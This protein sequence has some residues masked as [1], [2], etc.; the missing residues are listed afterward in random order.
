MK[1]TI[2]RYWE[3][4]GTARI[5]KSKHPIWEFCCKDADTNQYIFTMHKMRGADVMALDGR[6]CTP[7]VKFCPFCGSQC[8]V[9]LEGES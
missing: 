3:P 1:A 8:V 5:L 6:L 4:I 9:S 7:S 2:E